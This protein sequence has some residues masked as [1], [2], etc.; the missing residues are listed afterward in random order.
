MI[1]W[2]SCYGKENVKIHPVYVS[3]IALFSG[4]EWTVLSDEV[5][6]SCYV[7]KE[8]PKGASYVFRVGC[9]TKMGAVPFSDTSAPVVMPT[10]PEGK[11]TLSFQQLL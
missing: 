7:V 1:H 6:D 3:H 10:Y 5:T 8:L 4:G 2:R 9:I 11:T